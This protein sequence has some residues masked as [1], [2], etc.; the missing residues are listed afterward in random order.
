VGT[1]PATEPSVQGTDSPAREPAA[2]ES[3]ASVS[4]A[5]DAGLDWVTV[6][7]PEQAKATE[8]PLRMRRVVAQLLVGILVVLVAVTVGGSFASRRLAEREAVNDAAKTADVLAEAVVQPI[9]TDKLLAGD[10]ASTRAFDKLVRDRVLG[11]SVVHVKLWTPQGTVLYAD[12]SEL[13]GKTFA[14]DAPQ[15][16][17]LAHPA[18]QADI[19][20]LDRSENAFDTSAGN[21]LVE[22]YRPVWTP[23]GQEVLFEIYTPYDEV[24]QR[25]S[26]LWRG[27]AGLTLTSL[28]LFVV[29]LFPL[30]WHLLTRVRRSQRQRELLLER[31]VDASS[32]ERRR[33]AA[34][35]HDGPVQDLA[36]ASFAVAGATA[37]AES[38]GQTTMADELRAVSGSVRTSI[39]AL[40]SLL[41]D[42]YPASLSQAGLAAALNDL[43]QTVRAPGLDVRVDHDPDEDL[44]LSADEE[45]LVYRVAQETLRNVA[46][47]ASPCT[48]TLTLF[49]DEGAVVL[50]VV[51]DGQGFDVAAVMADPEPGHLG[52]Q[53]LSDLASSGGAVLQVASAPGR[54]THWRLALPDVRRGTA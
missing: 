48:V 39:R 50:D 8:A 45:R 44:A 7:S 33:I 53:L 3:G 27:F 25:T 2:G 20:D 52:L 42:I 30:M 32:V 36:A 28:L 6:G 4:E 17:V 38:T 1:D 51:D 13:I 54:G 9:L 41:V 31:A 5:L 34:S 46:K 14:L 23:T 11:E 24:S 18:T 47:H 40:R 43:A 26:Q 19:S 35:L 15:K 22:V 16:E 37:T 12:E 29:L 21:R 49:R 10:K